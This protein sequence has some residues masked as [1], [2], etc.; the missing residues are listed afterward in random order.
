MPNG[1]DWALLDC[2]GI[3]CC[4]DTRPHVNGHYV[5]IF[6]DFKQKT[7]WK[8]KHFHFSFNF[9]LWLFRLFQVH[10][11]P[12][13][14][15][16]NA[17]SNWHYSVKL[18]N[19]WE[20]QLSRLKQSDVKQMRDER[21]LSSRWRTTQLLHTVLL[22]SSSQHRPS[23]LIWLHIWYVVNIAWWENLICMGFIAK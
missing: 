8:Q 1:E 16:I 17:R 15:M 23:Y 19:R 10:K 21:Q 11:N 12:N 9:F 2:A 7:W 3:C 6:K 18:C 14:K 13:R 4:I 22:C 20:F 5:P